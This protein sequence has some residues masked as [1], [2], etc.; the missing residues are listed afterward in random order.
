MC[1]YFVKKNFLFSLI[2]SFY[3]R[4]IIAIRIIYYKYSFLFL[5]KKNKFLFQWFEEQFVQLFA[6][7]IFRFLSFSFSSPFSF[8]CC[9]RDRGIK[10]VRTRRAAYKRVER[11]YWRIVVRSI[12]RRLYKARFVEPS[13]NDTHMYHVARIIQLLHGEKYHTAWL[14]S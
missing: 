10:I 1:N 5:N 8:S 13:K 7:W 12:S 6:H 4:K 3:T 9:N 2:K 14:D 11:N